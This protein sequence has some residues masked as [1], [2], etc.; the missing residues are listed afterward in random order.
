M[1][2]IITANGTRCRIYNY[3]CKH[4]EL[5]LLKD[6]EHPEGKLKSGELIADTPG[7]YKTRG[8]A[9]GACE[10]S[11]DP[12]KVEIGRFIKTVADEIESGRTHNSYKE[13]V[14]FAP[15]EVNG[16][17]TQ[18]LSK[19][20]N[21]L[22]IGNIKKDYVAKSERDLSAYLHHNWREIINSGVG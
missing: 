14:I 4:H 2:W 7:H 5:S 22:M 12:K 18:H 6:L 17:L 13:V 21:Q 19:Q 15:P 20:T 11:S 8:P 3:D 1:A 16:M 10:W 9:R